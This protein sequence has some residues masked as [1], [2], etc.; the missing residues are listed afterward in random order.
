MRIALAG[1]LALLAACGG[2][3]GATTEKD[4]SANVAD[5]ASIDGDL[6]MAPPGAGAALACRSTGKN[7][8]LTYGA[9]AFAKVNDSI[10][11]RVS[12][13]L[14]ANGSL[15]LGDS[16]TR[17]GTGVPASTADPIGSFKGSLLAFLVY[18]Y[19]GPSYLQYSDG[20]TYSGV[21][22]MASAHRW[23]SC[24]DRDDILLA[25]LS[26]AMAQAVD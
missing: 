8:F 18:A 4:A 14:A 15:N 6:A 16:L 13:E 9:T 25:I 20:I 17:V 11:E 23:L 3:D 10:F 2:S 1:S 26:I 19:G 24:K 22:D 7:A 12:S 5:M 21:R